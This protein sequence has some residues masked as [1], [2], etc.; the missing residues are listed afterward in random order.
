[1]RNGIITNKQLF[2]WPNGVELNTYRILYDQQ[3]WANPYNII[4][5]EDSDMKSTETS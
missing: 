4:S 2:K 3:Q 1:M 5:T